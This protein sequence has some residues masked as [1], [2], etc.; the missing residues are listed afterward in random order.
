MKNIFSLLAV[1]VVSSGLTIGIY[2]FYLRPK[3]G[4]PQT[5][6]VIYKESNPN[7][8][9]TANR[10]PRASRLRVRRFTTRFRSSGT[11][12]LGPVEAPLHRPVKCPIPPPGV[13]EPFWVSSPMLIDIGQLE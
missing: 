1:S 4:D 9:Q 12:K 7:A 13:G 8:Y 10:R 5:R 6:E 2:E 11:Q 3:L